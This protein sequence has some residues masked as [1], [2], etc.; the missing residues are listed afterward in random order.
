[1]TL[2]K[3]N[4]FLT[5]PN[6]SMFFGFIGDVD[7]LSA[8]QLLYDQTYNFLDFLI[9]DPTIDHLDV[10]F[11]REVILDINELNSNTLNVEPRRCSVEEIL[12][13]AARRRGPNGLII[14]RIVIEQ[15]DTDGFNRMERL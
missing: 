1:M 8:I 15:G 9:H 12:P 10:R 6:S 2:T 4:T 14:P 13:V 11:G 3:L 7:S 5:N